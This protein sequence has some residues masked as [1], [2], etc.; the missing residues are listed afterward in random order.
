MSRY[1]QARTSV[2]VHPGPLLFLTRSGALP[3][4]VASCFPCSPRYSL[5]TRRLTHAHTQNVFERN[6]FKWFGCANMT[7]HR[8]YQHRQLASS[9]RYP[10]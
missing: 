9:R 3:V 7:P 1:V 5:S 4:L 2:W 8:M 6:Y 10:T